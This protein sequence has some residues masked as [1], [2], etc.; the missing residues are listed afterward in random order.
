MCLELGKSQMSV[1]IG[2]RMGGDRVGIV[3]LGAQGQGWGQRDISG[4]GGCLQPVLW[5]VCWPCLSGV[6][7]GQSSLCLST[8][9]S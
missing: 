8:G 2:L 1:S 9:S 7:W 5:E 6:P 4:G 3:C